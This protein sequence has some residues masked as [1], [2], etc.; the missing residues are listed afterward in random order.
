MASASSSRCRPFTLNRLLPEVWVA[1]RLRF[2]DD[3]LEVF[4]ASVVRVTLA[5]FATKAAPETFDIPCVVW[6]VMT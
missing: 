2:L 3:V 4:L 1:V 5:V 6:S